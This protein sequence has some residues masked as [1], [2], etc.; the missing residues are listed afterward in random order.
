MTG[1]LL[2]L[3]LL[4]NSYDCSKVCALAPSYEHPA[5]GFL[6]WPHTASQ[7]LTTEHLLYVPQ[8]LIQFS[9]PPTEIDASFK[10]LSNPKDTG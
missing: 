4:S 9:Q 10:L 8:F 7:W 2:P 6:L 3:R 1:P 5:P